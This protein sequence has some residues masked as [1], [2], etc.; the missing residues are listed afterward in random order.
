[1]R[2]AINAANRNP[3]SRGIPRTFKDLCRVWT[4]RAIHD[5][6]EF[7]NA[8]EIMNALAGHNLNKDQGDYLET[9]S[10]LVD[11]FDRSHNE[12]PSK[13]S[14]LAVLEYLLEEHEI[15]GRE[16]GRILGNESIGGFILR[17]ERSIT[18][19][20]AKKLGEYFSVDPSLFLDL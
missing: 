19:E 14:P 20:Q 3:F 2:K 1:M 6:A 18:V 7:E 9:V 8:S 17:G 10:I 15:S 11:E 4:P 16:L 12:Q 5:S 13:A